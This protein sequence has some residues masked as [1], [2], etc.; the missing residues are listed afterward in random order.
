MRAQRQV[1][2]THTHTHTQFDGGLLEGECLV[3]AGLPDGGVH[4][5]DN[6]VRLNGLLDLNHLVE[7]GLLLLVA[8]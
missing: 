2:H 7:E 4:G 5:E 3:V 6:I 1:D 8:A